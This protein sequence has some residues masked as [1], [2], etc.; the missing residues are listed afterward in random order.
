MDEMSTVECV[1]L[2]DEEFQTEKEELGNVCEIFLD[3]QSLRQSG[4][5]IVVKK[6]VK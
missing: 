5:K 6:C 4:M 1:E 3:Q 2:S